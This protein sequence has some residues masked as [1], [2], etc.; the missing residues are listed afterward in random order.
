MLRIKWLSCLLILCCLCNAGSTCLAESDTEENLDCLLEISIA[1]AGE[2]CSVIA[3]EGFAERNMDKLE[4]PL[5]E[6]LLNIVPSDPDYMT[7]LS[8]PSEM[9]MNEVL[10]E[11]KLPGS[12]AASF[13]F[14]AIYETNTIYTDHKFGEWAEFASIYDICDDIVDVP[15]AM[16]TVLIYSEAAPQIVT[17][18]FRMNDS[19]YMTKTSFVYNDIAMGGSICAAFPYIAS[20]IWGDL[21]MVNIDMREQ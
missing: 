21:D 9:H 16:Y 2:L 5:R 15:Q 20:S 6:L 12:M 10:A 1:K 19:T 7:V 18:F 3:T 4:P 17:A 13:C 11:Y 14:S 8:S